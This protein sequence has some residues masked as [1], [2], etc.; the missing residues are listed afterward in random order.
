MS[1]E[2]VNKPEASQRDAKGR[3]GHGNP[4]GPGNPF[5]RQVASLRK[6]LLNCGTPEHIAIV[7]KALFDKA[8][9]GDVMAMKIYLAYMVGKPAPTVDPDR[10]DIDEWQQLKE[11]AVMLPE[12]PML[13][14]KPVP[15]FPLDLVRS[16][17]AAIVPELTARLK[18]GLLHPE[19]YRPEYPDLEMVEDEVP[20][21]KGDKRT[22]APSS[23]GVFDG[24]FTR[25]DKLRVKN[26]TERGPSTNGKVTAGGPSTDGKK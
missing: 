10:L 1:T 26:V 25:P 15:E 7:V 20:S 14:T 13:V 16:A 5:A 24:R 6:A 21:T 18:D 9:A 23:N 2:T 12:A 11:E 4:G 8:A 3:F 19:K 17:R 22:G